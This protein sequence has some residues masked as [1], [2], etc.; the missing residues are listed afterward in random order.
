MTN[1]SETDR[2][3][4]D[5]AAV[6]RFRERMSRTDV[7][8]EL[9]F[10]IG[11]AQWRTGRYSMA[12]KERGGARTEIA[13][14]RF[15]AADP[16]GEDRAPE[17]QCQADV[18][19]LVGSVARLRAE[20]GLESVVLSNQTMRIRQPAPGS[21][22]RVKF[23]LRAGAGERFA[24]DRAAAAECH[25]RIVRA[26]RRSGLVVE[27]PRRFAAESGM[28]GLRAW[29]SELRLRRRRRPWWLLLPLL[30]LLLLLPVPRSA[31]AEAPAPERFF[32]VPIAT[33]SLLVLVDKSGSMQAHFAAVRAEAKRLLARIEASGDARWA[34]VVAYDQ[35]A[36]SAL[37]GLAAVDAG[38]SRS[39]LAFLDGLAAGGGTH[40]RAGIEEAAR[41]V[42]EH[43]RPTTLVIL[44]DGQDGSIRAMLQQMDPVLAR[45]AGV[46]IVGHAVTP[47]FF[48][49]RPGDGPPA[50]GSSAGPLPA[51]QAE[52][53]LSELA[54]RLHGRFG[55][56]PDVHGQ[57]KRGNT[58]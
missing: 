21:G 40:L 42:A 54:E 6:A 33:E 7:A 18:V 39:L 36:H 10:P 13:G 37:P 26:V 9:F 52:R 34:N 22:S 30:L 45:F 1:S 35:A 3:V 12:R 14:V 41:Q 48:R 51:D 20:P 29:G 58:P 2:S 49:S 19:N 43:G 55:P 53:D 25:R 15:Q 31:G 47:R 27:H 46:S 16:T 50:P 4:L 28:E 44:T 5:P 32:G 57:S 11:G 8:A 56:E 23:G 17:R 24:D 38:T